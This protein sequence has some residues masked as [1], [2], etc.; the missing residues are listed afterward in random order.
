M[1]GRVNYRRDGEDQEQEVWLDSVFVGLNNSGVPISLPDLK[2]ISAP[3]RSLSRLSEQRR[4]LVQDSRFDVYQ[5]GK[6]DEGVPCYQVW[7]SNDPQVWLNRVYQALS[8]AESALGF[9]ELNSWVPAPDEISDWKS[10]KELLAQVSRNECIWQPSPLVNAYMSCSAKDGRFKISKSGQTRGGLPIWAI[11]VCQDFLAEQNMDDMQGYTAHAQSW[12]DSVF[13]LLTHGKG[14]ESL[15]DLKNSTPSHEVGDYRRMRQWLKRDERFVV[16]EDG[17]TVKGHPRYHVRLADA[18][19]DAIY[20]EGAGEDEVLSGPN[21]EQQDWL[22]QV[23]EYLHEQKETGGGMSRSLMD[24]IRDVPA[25]KDVALEGKEIGVQRKLLQEDARFDVYEGGWTDNGRP[26]WYV[27]L[28]EEVSAYDGAEGASQSGVF[29]WQSGEDDSCP[30]YTKLPPPIIPV[31]QARVPPDDLAA[32]VPLL[33]GARKVEDSG[34]EAHRGYGQACDTSIG[35]EK[36]PAR[37]RAEDRQWKREQDHGRTD[38]HECERREGQRRRNEAL[39]SGRSGEP[40]SIGGGYARE[41][42]RGSLGMSVCRE[43]WS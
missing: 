23:F 17:E 9:S 43:K 22:D 30:F 5:D 16:Y 1:L 37:E 41:R 12:L 11:T 3:P 26:R 4:L 39:Q 25:G 18:I 38:A 34:G 14:Y 20:D 32:R 24:L 28:N 7:F 19:Y 21:H 42:E 35:R 40:M 6:T 13:E 33:T 31:Q 29:K 8:D 27:C 10:Q 15:P 2:Q 36:S